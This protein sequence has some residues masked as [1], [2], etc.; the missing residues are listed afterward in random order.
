[1]LSGCQPGKNL[2]KANVDQVLPGMA[3]KQVESILGLPTSVDVK[4][5]DLTKKTTYV[6]TQGEESVTLTFWDDKLESKVSTFKE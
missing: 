6:Y 5:L 2:T 1:M 3:K 4:E